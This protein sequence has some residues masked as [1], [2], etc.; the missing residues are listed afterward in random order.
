MIAPEQYEK[1]DGHK[2]LSLEF[3]EDERYRLPTEPNVDRPVTTQ[4]MDESDEGY[5]DDSED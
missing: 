5:I 2:R 3:T 4:G 1:E